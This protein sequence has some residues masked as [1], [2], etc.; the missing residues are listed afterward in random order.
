MEAAL[1]VCANFLRQEIWVVNVSGKCNFNHFGQVVRFLCPRPSQPAA[2]LL[3]SSSSLALA[4]LA[5]AFCLILSRLDWLTVP[6]PA[7]RFVLFFS[8]YFQ[9]HFDQSAMPF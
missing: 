6:T 2:A 9:S 5:K 8:S 1:E 3:V 4:C 7:G